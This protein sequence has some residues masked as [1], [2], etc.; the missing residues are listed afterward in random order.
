MPAI[1]SL[2]GFLFAA[3][4]PLGVKARH[5]PMSA[6]C[7]LHPNK[8]TLIIGFCTSALGQKLT[9]APQ[10]LDGRRELQFIGVSR[11]ILLPDFLLPGK[12]PSACDG[13]G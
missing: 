9:H 4:C 3:Q 6:S 8:Q 1:C 2:I 11:E 10:Q 5:S 7:L 13:N 12:G